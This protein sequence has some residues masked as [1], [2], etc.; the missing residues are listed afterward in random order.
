M[1]KAPYGNDPAKI[2]RYKDF[3]SRADV[4]R[5]LVGFTFVGWFP[6]G[7]F[8]ACKNWG[9]SKYLTPDMIDPAAFMEDH[10]RMM[11][12]GEVVDDDL[13]RGAGPTQVAVPFLPGALGCKVRILSDNVMGEEQNLS[14]EEALQVRLDHHNPWFRKYRGI[15]P[16]AGGAIRRSVSGQPRRRSGAHR[17]ARGIARA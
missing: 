14:W 17:S 11:R 13:L 12:E 5:P 2:E 15:W 9:S 8:A 7:E 3:W 16:G 4:K 6:F 1:S 10:L